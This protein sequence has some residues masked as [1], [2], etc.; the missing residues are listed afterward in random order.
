MIVVRFPKIDRSEMMN[1]F[2]SVWTQPKKTIEYVIENKSIYY[3]FFL[4][5]LAGLLGGL[6]G[7]VDTGFLDDFSL[8]LIILISLIVGLL[9]GVI[10]SVIMAGVYLLIGKMLGGTGTFRNMLTVVGV[11]GILGMWTAPLSILAIF[12]FGKEL[13]TEPTLYE[14]SNMSIGFYLLINLIT[15][16]VGIYAIV[17]QSKGIGIVHN[18]SSYRGFGTVAIFMGVMFIFMIIAIFT[19]LAVVFTIGY[20]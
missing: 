18:F 16:G 12:L 11:T 2:L 5:S 19:V 20:S 1:P 8:T 3:V 4:I 9:V 10:G 15:I 17:V 13:F 6:K 14:I 7:F